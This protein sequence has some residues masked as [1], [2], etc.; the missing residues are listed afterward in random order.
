MELSEKSS[1]RGF[2]AW[3]AAA[4]FLIL[5]LGIQCLL[6][7]A[8]AQGWVPRKLYSL[9]IFGPLFAAIA[10]SF[11]YLGMSGVRQIF[12]SL[13]KW[14]CGWQW[15]AFCLIWLTLFSFLLLILENLLMGRGFAPIPL[16]FT[17][18]NLFSA[19]RD[20]VLITRSILR[21][22]IITAVIEEVAWVSCCM[23]LLRHYF[24]PLV[25]SLIT[26]VFWCCWW[27]PVIL[28]GDGVIAGLPIPVLFIHYMGLAATC[29]WVYHFTKS[30]LLVIV[31]Q[32]ITNMVSLVIPVLPD[33]GGLGTY[34]VYVVS[35]CVLIFC[36]FLKWGPKPLWRK[37]D[38][39]SAKP[40]PVTA[41]VPHVA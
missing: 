15:Y 8:V 4:L 6:I 29:M 39:V 2:P 27:V 26:S 7:G 25:A 20:Q 38:A 31:M 34:I 41:P 14:R 16:D 35:K 9:R 3:K 22:S 5:C 40:T 18:V 13:F 37:T 12:S 21:G 17:N 36:L 28:F 30:A 19:D 24:T 23:M 10:A 33:S 1:P 32:F 11:C